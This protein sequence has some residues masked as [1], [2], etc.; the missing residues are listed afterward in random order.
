MISNSTGLGRDFKL[1][2]QIN[3]SSGSLMDN[4]AEGFGLGGNKEFIQFL[5]IAHASG[6]ET[7]S[8]LYRVRDRQYILQ[9]DFERLYKLAGRSRKA[10]MELI[11][12]L[13]GS[14]LRG[15]RFK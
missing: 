12:Y 11:N 6:A 9:P 5:E 13:G 4:I 7:Q 14:D 1:R 10:I 3:A 8:Q 15:P 2:D